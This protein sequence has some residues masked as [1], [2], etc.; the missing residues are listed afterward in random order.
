MSEALREKKIMNKLLIGL[1]I[2]VGVSSYGYAE[3]VIIEGIIPEGSS[4]EFSRTYHATAKKS[5]CGHWEGW[6]GPLKEWVGKVK[7]EK[8]TGV[9]EGNRYQIAIELEATDTTNCRY[10]SQTVYLKYSVVLPDGSIGSDTITITTLDSYNHPKIPELKYNYSLSCQ[11]E[12]YGVPYTRHVDCSIPNSYLWGSFNIDR[13]LYNS[14]PIEV[15][16]DL[17]HIL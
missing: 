13:K 7:S 1:L 14:T 3:V 11:T 15:N 8:G 16:V 2:L 12:V 6:W 9:V 4:V 17:K 10:Y 5:K